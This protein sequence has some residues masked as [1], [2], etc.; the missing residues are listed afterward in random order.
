M[1]L[2]LALR[3]L[4]AHPVRTAVLAAGFGLGVAVM[5]VLLGVG[6]VVLQQARSPE[7]AGGGDVRVAGSTGRVTAARVLLGSV[8]RSPALEPRVRIASPWRR[9]SLYLTSGD[10]AGEQRGIA[11]R[12]RAGIPSLERALGDA[13]T[14]D[15][16]DWNDTRADAAWTAPEPGDLLRTI[17]R[18]H[19]IP[20]V[21]ERAGSWAEW[22]YFNGRSSDARF[23]LTFTVGPRAAGGRTASVHLQ[24]DRGRGEESFGA[25][26]LVDE[27]ALANTPDL[28][29]ANN[30]VRIDGLAYRIRLDLADGKGRRAQGELVVRGT[31][32]GLLPPVE[33]HG[34]GGWRSGYVVPVI[35]GALAGSLLVG[36]DRISFDNGSGYHDHNWG[37]WEGVSWEWGQVRHADLSLVYGRIFPP[38]D[39][40]DSERIP[41]FIGAIGPDGPLGYATNVVIDHTSGA[42]GVPSEIVVRGRAV[43]FDM[44]IRFNVQ[45]TVVRE[46]GRIGGDMDFLQMRGEYKVSGRVGTRAIEFAAPGSAET[47]RGRR[48][49]REAQGAQ[50]DQGGR[51]VP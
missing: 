50:G 24:L 10:A 48:S 23:Y 36:D 3:S 37:F 49:G 15:Q 21:P 45:D 6:Q 14:A 2:T 16:P 32:G 9:A 51:G 43:A 12:A 17:D 19:P 11:V 20:D 35:S 4:L 42:G 27:A 1:I 44:T 38:R 31:K 29:I 30:H 34:A 5:A 25:V 47:F 7:L 39:A 26:A 40:A 33:V 28:S 13:E 46:L 41:G 8:L 18:F 22:L